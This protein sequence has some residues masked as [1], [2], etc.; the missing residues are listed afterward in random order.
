MYWL[1]VVANVIV[2]YR[3]DYQKRRTWATLTQRSNGTVVL[4]KNRIFSLN[5]YVRGFLGGP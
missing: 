4:K 5:V 2:R 3:T 1:E